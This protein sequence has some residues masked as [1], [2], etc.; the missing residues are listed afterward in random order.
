MLCRTANGFG[1]LALAAM[2]AGKAS[3][4][5]GGG[6]SGDP[7]MPR[8]PH[9]EPKA[10]SIIFLFMDGGPSQVD[11][12]DPKPL[13]AKESGNPIKMD[14]PTTVFNISNLVLD[15][16]F[17]FKKHGQ[18]G[19]DVSELFPHVATCVDDM[20]IIR[21]MVTN[22]SEH[23]AGNYFM[24]SGSG[25]QDVPAWAPGQPTD[26]EASATTC[27]ASSSWNRA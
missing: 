10:K 9:F 26:W 15:S 16:P 19:A 3:A 20:A 14:T 1:G 25:F 18:C 12:F 6:R 2:L 4:A 7:M 13:L 11:T 21:S 5:A 22:H 8:A 23:T 27:P 24:H 17:K